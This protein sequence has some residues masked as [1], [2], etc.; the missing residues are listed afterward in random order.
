MHLKF[1]LLFFILYAL[2]TFINSLITSPQGSARA[3]NV[4]ANLIGKNKENDKINV[5]K[6]AKKAA[7]VLSGSVQFV[8]VILLIFVNYKILLIDLKSV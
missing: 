6:L 3:S 7:D 4:P 2:I 5:A 1:I 8:N